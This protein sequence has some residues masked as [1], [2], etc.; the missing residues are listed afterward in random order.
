MCGYPQNAV[1][2]KDDEQHRRDER[3]LRRVPEPRR[4]LDR[5]EEREKPRSLADHVEDHVRDAKEDDPLWLGPALL[6]SEQPLEHE[7]AIA[8]VGSGCGAR[9]DKSYQDLPALG[10]GLSNLPRCV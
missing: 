6:V 7:A 1:D 3:D 8:L 2:D 4:K 5:E 9:D 10:L